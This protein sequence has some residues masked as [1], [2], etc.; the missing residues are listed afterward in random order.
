MIRRADPGTVDD[1]QCRI[2]GRKTADTVGK[3]SGVSGEL[4]EINVC[5][6]FSENGGHRN[7]KR[8]QTSTEPPQAGKGRVA[9]AMRRADEHDPLIL[10]FA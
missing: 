3:A 1:F 4:S 9:S 8:D 10:G 2:F 6:R 5:K 7:G